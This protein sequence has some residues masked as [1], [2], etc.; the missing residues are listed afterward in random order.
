MPCDDDVVCLSGK[1]VRLSERVW[2]ISE[3]NN[4]IEVTFVVLSDADTTASGAGRYLEY[5]VFCRVL[6]ILECCLS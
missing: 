2:N 1:L 6:P 4:N 3:S 5:S